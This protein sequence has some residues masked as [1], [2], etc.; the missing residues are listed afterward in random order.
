MIELSALGLVHLSNLIDPLAV[1]IY[2]TALTIGLFLKHRDKRY[3]TPLYR[4]KQ[5]T[6][7]NS[8]AKHFFNS[9]GDKA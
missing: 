5:P 6:I 9:C 2:R 1:Q 4:K 8:T 3:S 7:V